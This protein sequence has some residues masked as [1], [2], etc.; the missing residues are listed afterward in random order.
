MRVMA[1]N[2]GKPKEERETPTSLKEFYET[3][4]TDACLVDVDGNE[5]KGI[6]A[7]FDGD[8]DGLDAAVA[9]FW[10]SLPSMLYQERASL[11]KS[12]RRI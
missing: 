6:D 9:S 10:A 5:F 2:H 1:S 3:F 12:L 8:V 11:G 4:V 7:I